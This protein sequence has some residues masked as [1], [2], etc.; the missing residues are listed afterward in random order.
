MEASPQVDPA[1]PRADEAG[2]APERVR[3]PRPW[4][5]NLLREMADAF[6]LDAALGFAESFG[7][8]YLHLPAEA[9]PDHP[10]AQACGQPLLA[11]LMERH[12]RLERIVVPKGP[13]MK[14]GFRWTDFSPEKNYFCPRHR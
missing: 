7:G 13:N 3:T 10:V 2:S 5:P 14:A 4:L 12:S 9:K 11:W 8:Q 6:G 1:C